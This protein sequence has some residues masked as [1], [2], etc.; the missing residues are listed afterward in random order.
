MILYLIDDGMDVTE[1]ILVAFGAPIIAL[2][3]LYSVN[4]TLFWIDSLFIIIFILSY[5]IKYLFSSFYIRPKIRGI[6]IIVIKFTPCI[7]TISFIYSSCIHLFSDSSF[8]IGVSNVMSAFYSGLLFYSINFEKREQFG[9]I[10]PY[11]KYI[12]FLRAFKEDKDIKID[13]ILSKYSK[14]IL[15]IGDP[16][17]IDGNKRFNGFTLFLSTKNWK[18]EVLYYIRHAEFV[19]CCLSTTDGVFWELSNHC[20]YPKKF[21]FY[22]NVLD[23]T[24]IIKKWKERMN[25]TN[26]IIEALVKFVGSN[27]EANIREVTFYIND[28]ICYYSN[29]ISNILNF[30]IKKETNS[31]VQTIKLPDVYLRECDIISRQCLGVKD[32][33][34]F[35]GRVNGVKSYMRLFKFLMYSLGA[36]LYILVA[37]L[38]IGSILWGLLALLGMVIIPLRE[39]IYDDVFFSG[40]VFCISNFFKILFVFWIGGYCFKSFKE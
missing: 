27:H 16:T 21:I 18:K 11:R 15:E 2:Y 25:S 17:S 36:F 1:Y 37:I 26:Q 5:L 19:F 6:L 31:N 7:L 30:V 32:I 22:V 14:N 34:R 23:I 4:N 35:W 33:V 20:R 40:D 24:T 13:S 29:D 9:I 3:S 28:N 12:F 10:Y 39:F 8:F 38:G